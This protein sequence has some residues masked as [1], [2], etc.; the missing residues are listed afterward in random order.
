MGASFGKALIGMGLTIALIGFAIVLSAKLPWLRLGR[1][2]GDI[3]I[4]RD[5]FSVFIPITTML[6]FSLLL[7][8][9]LMVV[10]RFKR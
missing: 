6:L 2:P 8:L 4:Q 10:G 3:N 1:L 7:S 9:A 5:G